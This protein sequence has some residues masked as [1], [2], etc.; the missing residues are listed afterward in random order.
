MYQKISQMTPRVGASRIS[1]IHR[2][3]NH[4]LF[5]FQLSS[6]FFWLGLQ[7]S[8]EC[9]NQDPSSLLTQLRLT[10]KDFPGYCCQ[11]M[12]LSNYFGANLYFPSKWSNF[13]PTLQVFFPGHN[14]N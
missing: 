10:L 3:P 14:E 6:I 9:Q 1:R 5:N 2:D 7:D 12:G 4:Q 8:V 11:L 13:D